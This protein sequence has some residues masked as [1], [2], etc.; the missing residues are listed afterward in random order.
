MSFLFMSWFVLWSNP[1]YIIV[2]PRLF[3]RVRVYIIS[4]LC[5]VFYMVC[6]RSV[7]C[8]Q[9][10]LCL[11]V[12]R[13]CLLVSSVFSNV[14][15]LSTFDDFLVIVSI[16]Y[17]SVLITTYI[18]TITQLCL[19]PLCKEISL[20]TQNLAELK[21]DSEYWTIVQFSNEVI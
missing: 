2:R 7:S 18:F 6:F 9:C 17:S 14:Y 21:F 16:T 13:S 12:V 1:L 10:C 4:I 19:I 8:V 20:K 11:C 5:C 3:D 15:C